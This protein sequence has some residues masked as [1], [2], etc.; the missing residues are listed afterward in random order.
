MAGE[1]WRLLADGLQQ[2]VRRIDPDAVVRLAVDAAGL[3]RIELTS[4]VLE[5]SEAQLIE[6]AWEARAASI[7]ERCG[8][9]VEVVSVAAPGVVLI[10]CSDCASK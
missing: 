7:C 5:A 10:L 4:N 8:D 6:R 2:E 1:A 9:Q 3:P